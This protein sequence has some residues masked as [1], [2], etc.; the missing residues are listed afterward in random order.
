MKTIVL[1]SLAL[2]GLSGV[3]GWAGF[4]A[5]GKPSQT[6]SE[7]SVLLIPLGSTVSVVLQ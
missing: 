6:K 1:L 2:V 7:D 3:A 4:S 5:S